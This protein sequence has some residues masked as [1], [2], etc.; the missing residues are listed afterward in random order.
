MDYVRD[1]WYVC[2][3]AHDVT[4]KKPIPTMVL[5]KPVVLWRSEGQ[6]VAFEDRCL[7]RA[8]PLSRGRCE[9]DAL[10]CMYHGFLY[11]SD[12]SVAE[13]PGQE[14]LPAG[15]KLKLYPIAERHGWVWIWMGDERLAELDLIPDIIGI[16]HGDYLMDHSHQDWDTE[17]YLIGDNLLDFSHVTYLHAQSF[18]AGTEFADIQPEW[19]LLDRGIRYSRWTP[20]TSSLT[21]SVRTEVVDEYLTYDFYV[22]GILKLM[23][24]L[25]PAGTAEE[26][27]FGRP[28][29]GKSLAGHNAS[30]QAVTPVC[31]GK[32]RY[33]FGEGTSR[34]H[35]DEARCD[36]VMSMVM[37]AFVEDRAMIEAQ[38][39]SI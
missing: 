38:Y 36:L 4:V 26:S 10:R 24:G 25:F 19:N 9:G 3:W 21:G 32:A 39:K 20:G 11:N 31:E 33:F 23:S 18:Q 34:D 16:D 27:G 37:Q 13:I 7:H 12:G 1:A 29:F 22:P 30:C 5:G 15:K 6:L 2:A 35:G 28:D 17:A 8:A 14:S